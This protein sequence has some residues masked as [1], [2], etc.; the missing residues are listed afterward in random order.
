MLQAI[1][2]R[3]W[4]FARGNQVEWRQYYYYND[5][6][7]D[8]VNLKIFQSV[9][10]HPFWFDFYSYQMIECNAKIATLQNAT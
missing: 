3:L 1:K 2:L 6:F 10:H 4:R 9:Q 8:S 5:Y 7:D